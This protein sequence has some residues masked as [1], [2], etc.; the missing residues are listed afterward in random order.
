MY[1]FQ[2]KMSFSVVQTRKN[3]NSKPVLSIVPSKWVST[4]N[5]RVLWPP[6][7]LISLSKDSNSEPNQ[8]WIPQQCKVLGKN[9]K[10][11]K[12][13]ENELSKF[14]QITDSDDAILMNRGTRQTPAMKK[15]YFTNKTYN[16]LPPQ[17]TTPVEVHISRTIFKNTNAN[18]VF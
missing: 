2:L 7:N 5:R 14:E 11:Y 6:N 15:Q 17:S 12:N 3:M 8:S 16:L 9:F 10:Q 4:D 1:I 18:F 13:A